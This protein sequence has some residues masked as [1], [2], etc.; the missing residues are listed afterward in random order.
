MILALYKSGSS[1]AVLEKEVAKTQVEMK[2]FRRMKHVTLYW[3]ILWLA[4]EKQL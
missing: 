1:R 3:R 2:F 4:D